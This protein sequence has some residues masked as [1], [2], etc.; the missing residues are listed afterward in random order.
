MAYELHSYNN[1]NLDNDKIYP[2]F[3]KPTKGCGSIDSY[4]INCKTE[5]LSS[6]D[7]KEN[8]LTV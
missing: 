2:L 7:I 1:E 8:I 4:K 5:I 6:L 3:I